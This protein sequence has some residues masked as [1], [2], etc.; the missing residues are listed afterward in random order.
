LPRVMDDPSHRAA[1]IDDV[2][3]RR[4]SRW[5]IVNVIHPLLSPLTAM[6][7]ANVAGAVAPEKIIQQH[8][9]DQGR[10][11]S[12][13]LQ[14]TFALL[15]QTHADVAEMFGEKKL[16]E[17][18]RAD[19]AAAELTANLASAMQRQREIAIE[20]IANRGGFFSAILRIL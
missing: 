18:L 15:Q 5:P 3:S 16:W 9:A 12:S 13:M 10:S 8:L 20:R 1:I 6:W 17:D 7:R 2:M 11:L 4:V 14:T 19:A